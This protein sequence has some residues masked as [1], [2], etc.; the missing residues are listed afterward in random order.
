MVQRKRRNQLL[1]FSVVALAVSIFA[2]VVWR[3]IQKALVL[4]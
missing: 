3:V 4:L 2:V 1:W